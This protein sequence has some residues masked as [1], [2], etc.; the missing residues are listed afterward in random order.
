MTRRPPWRASV[1][2]ACTAHHTHTHYTHEP[3]SAVEPCALSSAT[4]RFAA[5][6]ADAAA[7]DDEATALA[8]VHCTI[9]VL[10]ACE[11]GCV[12]ECEYV[13][14]LVKHVCDCYSARNARH[15]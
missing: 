8:R 15:K 7:A 2:V 13:S 5:R 11:C 14:A 6:L 12:R 4:A 3:S 1:D 9:S 10:S